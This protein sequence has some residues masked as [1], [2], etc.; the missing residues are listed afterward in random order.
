MRKYLLILL[1]LFSLSAFSQDSNNNIQYNFE[2][3]Y[4]VLEPRDGGTE[5]IIP[6]G[7][8]CIVNYN[9]FYKKYFIGWT[10]QK[11][12]TAGNYFYY[13]PNDIEKENIIM[14][15]DDNGGRYVIYNKVKELDAIILVFQNYN[16]DF[17]VKIVLTIKK[18]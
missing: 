11:G 16:K 14:T 12:I 9:T 10:D 18:M 4:Y 8:N 7:R 13:V 17:L 15:K 5:K 1:L 6:T 3:V 2:Y